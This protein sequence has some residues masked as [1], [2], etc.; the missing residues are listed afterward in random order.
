MMYFYRIL[1]PAL[2]DVFCEHRDHYQKKLPSDDKALLPKIIPQPGTSVP[3][4]AVNRGLSNG[5][6]RQ[7]PLLRRDCA[8]GDDCLVEAL[9]GKKN[10][11]LEK[12][13]L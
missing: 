5:N 1:F 10:S 9:K 8:L 13:V 7:S 4:A 3:G 11:L 2:D 12:P 6:P